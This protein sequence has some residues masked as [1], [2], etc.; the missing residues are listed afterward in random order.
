MVS[1]VR[2]RPYTADDRAAC[3]A[4][5]DG[6]TPLYF[7]VSERPLFEAFLGGEA[8]PYFVLEDGSGGVVACGGV[9]LYP[10]AGAGALLSPADAGLT[11]GMVARQRHRQGL[12]TRLVRERVAWLRQ[13]HSDVQVLL[14]ATS[15]HARRFYEGQGF[16][17]V[18]ITSDGFAPGLDEVQMRLKL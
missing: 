6:N 2:F 14:L 10:S 13:H 18:R 1:F 3:L 5:F 7:G 12:G 17:A 4:L 11:W 9:A 16:A 8:Q 15:Q